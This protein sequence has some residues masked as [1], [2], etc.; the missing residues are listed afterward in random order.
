MIIQKMFLKNNVASCL[1]FVLLTSVLAWN[2]YPCNEEGYKRY[3]EDYSSL[4]KEHPEGDI[5]VSNRYSSIFWV[6]A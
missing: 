2:R 4:G 5:S 6:K 1:F 3:L